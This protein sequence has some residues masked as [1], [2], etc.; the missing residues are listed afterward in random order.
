[1]SHYVEIEVEFD[2]AATK[3]LIE[4]LEM[5]FG[6]GNVE[7]HPNGSDLFGYEGS[8]RS[9][10]NPKSPDYSPPCEIVVRR[11]HVGS[12]A[13][14][15]GFKAMPNGKYKAF[16]SEY[17]NGNTFTAPKRAKVATEYV[18]KVFEREAKAKG[19]TKIE[20]IEENGKTQFKASG[21]ISTKSA[22]VAR[23]KW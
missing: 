14:D 8:N 19:Y 11:R 2:V 16:V 10:M 3:E 1:M 21:K 20:R 17:D 7:Y 23:V 15:V 18:G 12:A 9:K 6:K 4:A 5:Q 22:G 13:N